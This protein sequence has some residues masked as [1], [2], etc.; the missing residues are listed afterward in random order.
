MSRRPP[1]STR[2][3]TL[4]PYTT[5][6][7]STRFAMPPTST[8]SISNRAPGAVRAAFASAID[9]FGQAGSRDTTDS[10]L[11]SFVTDHILPMLQ[12]STATLGSRSGFDKRQVAV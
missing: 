8:V 9:I 1:R 10:L 5:L 6:F 7:R 12:L 3:D 2:T 11:D 4:V